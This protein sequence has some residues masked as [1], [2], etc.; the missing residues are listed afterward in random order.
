L[1]RDNAAKLL[2]GKTLVAR[3]RWTGLAFD[4]ELD[5]DGEANEIKHVPALLPSLAAA[6][7]RF[8]ITADRA[9]GV[10][11]V[12]RNIRERRGEFLLRQHGVT[13]FVADPNV[14]EKRSTDRFGR[15]VIERWGW[16]TRG[17]A[18]KLKPA[19]RLAVR[20]INVERDH[21]NL[22][23]ITSLLDANTYPA[24][25][26]LDVYL[27]R[28]DIEK[29][30]QIVTEVFGLKPLAS[31]APQGMLLQFVLCALL[32]NVIQLVKLY[33][34]QSQKMSEPEISGEMLFRDVAEELIA[35]ARLLPAERVAKLTPTL[36]VAAARQRLHEL[37]DNRWTSRWK[38]ANYRPRNPAAAKPPKP[39]RLKQTK[40]HDSVQR[41]MQRKR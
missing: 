20:Q 10:F 28:W 23:L 31:T 1:D 2:G 11:E 41:I 14:A 18:T 7:E 5:L 6:T 21:E 3:D 8:L 27:D 37:L 17:Q 35:A 38:K 16:I 26:L 4:L 15:V 39:P 19:E 12:C 13:K 24:D 32:Y 30:F 40:S 33:I 29:M 25:A 34:A 36:D 9:F 22:T